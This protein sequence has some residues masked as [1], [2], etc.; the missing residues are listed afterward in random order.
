MKPG[1]E[2]HMHMGFRDFGDQGR[3]TQD[4]HLRMGACLITIG[5]RNRQE[6]ASQGLRGSEFSTDTDSLAEAAQ[7]NARPLDNHLCELEP[8][9]PW[10]ASKQPWTETCAV[11]PLNSVAD[12]KRNLIFL[13]LKEKPHDVPA[14][15]STQHR[16]EGQDCSKQACPHSEG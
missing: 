4:M 9:S 5:V 10:T 13:C 14:P 16:K 12:L 11:K 15:A 3:S 2:R 8:P 1:T 6:P 7:A